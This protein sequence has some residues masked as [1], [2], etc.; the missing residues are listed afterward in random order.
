[1]N[2][3]FFPE[4]L[5]HLPGQFRLSS[6]VAASGAFPGALAAV[7]LNAPYTFRDYAPVR[8]DYVLSDGGVADNSGLVLLDA[9]ELLAS[10]AQEVADGRLIESSQNPESKWNISRWNIDFILASDGSALAPEQS[11]ASG[12][13]E[14][15]RAMDVMN[16][17]TG[18]MEMFAQRDTQRRPHRPIILLSP[19]TFTI[20]QSEMK[21][22]KPV[23]FLQSGLALDS[24]LGLGLP[25]IGFA[26]I[27]HDAFAF[28]ICNMPVK[29]KAE[30]EKLLLELTEAGLI[31]SD[32]IQHLDLAKDGQQS[33]LRRLVMKELDRRL[34]AFVETTT[35]RDQIDRQTAES[36]YLLGRYL[37]WLNRRYLVCHLSQAEQK[38]TTHQEPD[39]HICE[40][41]I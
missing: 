17:T 28:I 29:E 31:T 39:P 12:F 7:R 33:R 22:G 30:A 25:S 41:L 10:E 3:V 14:F 36:I 21:K 27:E 32:G 34:R 2:A 18:G 24:R 9:A 19:R 11:P 37:V 40:T 5:A 35:L 15:V 1:M 26:S 23:V 13:D 8:F 6:L 38:K 16:I 4:Q 20:G